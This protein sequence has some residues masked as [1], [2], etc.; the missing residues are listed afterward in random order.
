MDKLINFP[1]PK[2]H[3]CTVEHSL[4]IKGYRLKLAQLHQELLGK[5]F[6]NAH[7]AKNDVYALV[8]C[9]HALVE[10]GDITL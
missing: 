2:N 4:H 5:G 8:R 7:R 10:R 9:F 1:W 6:E 3:I